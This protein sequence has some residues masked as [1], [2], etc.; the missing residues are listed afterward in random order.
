MRFRNRIEEAT[1]GRIAKAYG[2]CKNVVSSISDMEREVKRNICENFFNGCNDGFAII[3]N[4]IEEYFA[5]NSHMTERDFH[6]ILRLS[7]KDMET[8]IEKQRKKMMEE[9]VIKDD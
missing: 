6:A 4:R 5:C 3:E 8:H 7:Y 2:F 9:D 1:I